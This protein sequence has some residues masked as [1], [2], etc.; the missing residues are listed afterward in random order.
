M[1]SA[2]QI[3]LIIFC[4]ELV[5]ILALFTQPLVTFPYKQQVTPNIFVNLPITVGLVKCFSPICDYIHTDKLSQHD[6]NKYIPQEPHQAPE[7]TSFIDAFNKM[8][9]SFHAADDPQAQP[10]VIASVITILA[11]SFSLLLGFIALFRSMS[12]S[13]NLPEATNLMLKSSFLLL[14]GISSYFFVTLKQTMFSHLPQ[15]DGVND[16]AYSYKAIF[17]VLLTFCVGCVAA[18]YFNFVEAKKGYVLIP[19]TTENEKN[20]RTWGDI[21]V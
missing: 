3:T 11:M 8:L 5:I 2:T 17:W 9:P 1:Y 12:E 18:A 21:S 7:D 10:Y 16:T 19:S 13:P 14:C 4:S 6:F 15:G 20:K